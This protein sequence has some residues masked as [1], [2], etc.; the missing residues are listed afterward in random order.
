LA[1]QLQGVA[2]KSQKLLTGFLSGQLNS[3]RIGMGDA[4]ALGGAFFDLMT[5]M[6]SDPAALANAHIDLFNEGM[7][8]WCHAPAGAAI[9][10]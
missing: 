5:K 9:G 8:V 4:S 2:E 7:T 10:A 3:G 1:N 6:M